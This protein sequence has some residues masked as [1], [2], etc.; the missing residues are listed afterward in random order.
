MGPFQ[1]EVFYESIILCL[2]YFECSKLKEKEFGK[3]KIPWL[4]LFSI[5]LEFHANYV[6]RFNY[7]TG[8]HAVQHKVTYVI[9]I[10]S[11]IFSDW[12][13]NFPGF[14]LHCLLNSLELFSN[15][16]PWF[17]CYPIGHSCTT[18]SVKIAEVII[19]FF[20]ITTKNWELLC[21]CWAKAKLVLGWTTLF[22]Y[23]YSSVCPRHNFQTSRATIV[24]F[25]QWLHGHCSQTDVWECLRDSERKNNSIVWSAVYS[26]LGEDV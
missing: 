20:V 18:R 9:L 6:T 19:C 8:C 14:F 11:N 7:D 5:S 24:L 4:F 12:Q 1:H 22:V 26:I 15:G 21:P 23:L 16:S 13:L 2:W 3:S 10:T 17:F 25:L